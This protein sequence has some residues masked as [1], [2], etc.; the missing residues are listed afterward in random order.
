MKLNKGFAIP[1]LVLTAGI[2]LAACGS[3][4]APA[5]APAVT[6]TVIASPAPTTPKPTTP[7]PAPAPTHTTYVQAPAAPAPAAPAAPA[8]QA[9][10]FLNSQTLY[11]SLASEQQSE[12]TAAPADDYYS[13]GTISVNV[14]CT[15]DGDGIAYI[16]TGSDQDGDTGY[17]DT[18]TVID[19]GNAWTD[20]GM[21]WTG[22]DIYIDGGVTNYWT[23][24]AYSS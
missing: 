15:P 4:K 18:V 8:Y 11:N 7:A 10:E 6:H 9:G 1:A 21:N 2:S 16:C 12:L 20:T 5:A 3:A 17:G 23:T 24:P 22:P 14:S 13:P 19:N